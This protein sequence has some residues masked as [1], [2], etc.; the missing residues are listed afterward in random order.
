MPVASLVAEDGGVEHTPGTDETARLVALGRDREAARRHSA[1]S[2]PVTR[3]GGPVDT[4]EQLEVILPSLVDIARHVTP[5]QMANPSPCE[6]FDVRGVLNHMIGGARFF[7]AQF[8]GDPA[9][10]PP[11]PGTDLAGDDP[12]ATFVDAMDELLAA[13]RV[14]GA[15]ERTVVAPFGEVPGAVVAQFLTLDGMVHAWDLATATGQT[16]APS[17]ELAAE[18]LTFAKQAI[19]PEMRDGDTFAAE[20][21]PPAGSSS[22]VQLVAFTGRAV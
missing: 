17:E 13:T 3:S 15:Y 18:V 11:A 8:R 7:A 1:S 14:P 2:T 20:V 21:T 22:L 9:P 19:A 5:D 16:Y 12:V 6:H 10:E 4:N